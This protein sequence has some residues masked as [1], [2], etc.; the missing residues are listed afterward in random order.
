[1]LNPDLPP[2]MT[3]A[4]AKAWLKDNPNWRPGQ[5]AEGR[6]EGGEGPAQEETAGLG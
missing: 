5:K 1:M 6:D 2:L 3:T 4:E